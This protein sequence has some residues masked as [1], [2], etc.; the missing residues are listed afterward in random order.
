MAAAPAP[1]APGREEMMNRM[2]RKIVLVVS[3]IIFAYVSVG[4]LLA[5]TNDDKSY[6]VLTVYS[7]V[8]EHIQ[9]DYVEEPNLHAATAG[10]LHGL[11]DSLDPQS[12][13]LSA[14]E[15]ADYK[16][17]TAQPEPAQAGVVLS[18]RFGYI[19]VVSVLPDSPAQKAGVHNGDILESIGGFSTD[20]MA[21][22]QANVL[23]SGPAG[24]K[25][26]VGIVRPDKPAPDEV[27]I[28][29]EK[30]APEH[31]TV[32]QLPND[33]TLLRIPS[34][35]PGMVAQ[36]REKLVALNGSDSKKVILDLR[37]AA[38]GQ[39][40]EGIDAAKLFLSSGTITTLKGQTVTA[41]TFS[42]DPAKVVWKN[43]VVALISDNTA[44]PAEILAAALS[45]NHRG[46]TVGV[47]TFGMASQQKW[48]ELDDGSALNL[49][50]AM[51]YTPAGKSI[52]DDGVAPSTPL[53]LV[54]DDL[55]WLKNYE[56]GKAA[57][58]PTADDPFIK[59]ALELLSAPPAAAPVKKAA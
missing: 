24:Q 54:A 49:T 11:L 14:L 42:A 47:R 15:Y 34:F 8:L 30:L 21:I 18:R 46:E 57:S 36:L 44:G 22:G 29:L 17:K 50:V 10:A 13:Y 28:T 56:E 5:K 45:G 19:M 37:D 2:T 59:K 41:Q 51:Y 7:E 26:K 20:R 9:H 48:I 40:Q 38:A 31:I 12:S 4:Y 25:V 52:A 33:V 6:R 53:H 16:K 39:D 58:S 35:E 55:A 3:A 27:E 23:L 32:E 43:P 1:A